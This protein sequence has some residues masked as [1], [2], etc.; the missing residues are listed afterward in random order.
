L[1]PKTPI[2]HMLLTGDMVDHI[3]SLASQD[4]FEHVIRTFWHDWTLTQNHESDPMAPVKIQGEFGPF[5]AKLINSKLVK[6]YT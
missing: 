1:V 4:Q 5:K 6:F 2:V 3:E